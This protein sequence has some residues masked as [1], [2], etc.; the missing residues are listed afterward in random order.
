VIENLP[1]TVAPFGDHVPVG[2]VDVLNLWAN[3][4]WLL[5]DTSN[6]FVHVCPTYGMSN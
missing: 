5:L 3:L 6:M 4:G 1:F 2:D